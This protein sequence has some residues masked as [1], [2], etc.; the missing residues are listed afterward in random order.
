ML[1]SDADAV[2]WMSKYLE[3]AG[4]IAR[5]LDVNWHLTLDVPGEYGE[6]WKPLVI[7]TGD[8]K[9]FASRYAVEN[10]ENVIYFLTA[11][12]DN[13]NSILSCLR[14]A[15]QNAMR[16]RDIIPTEMWEALNVLYH[17]IQDGCKRPQ[18][19][20]KDPNTFC[21]EVKW[22]NLIIG[23]I[24]AD[25]MANDEA[26]R[27]FAMG[28]LLERADKTSRI[29]DVKYFMLLPSLDHV[30][31]ALDTVQW[32][33][34][35]KAVGG[36]QAFRHTH[37]RIVPEKVAEFMILNHEFP[38]SILYCLT[39][40]QQCLHDITGTRIGYF[41]NPAELQLG[42][43]CAGLSYHTIEEIFEQ[44]L[45]EFTDDLQIRF[46]VLGKAVFDTFFSRLPAI[47]QTQD[48]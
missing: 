41:T 33:A 30:G 26:W 23:G 42:Q 21:S 17:Y 31:T 29:L 47:E 13:P 24:A 35:L 32:A 25:I 3:R 34:L 22:R 11:D 1:S 46:N 2:Y 5:F 10:K 16:I 9:D 4:N 19:I 37:G 18:I 39:E 15:R 20:L 27:F 40:A 36:F 12:P 44:G 28:K 8:E 14:M 6:Q 48:Q 45:H 38:R 43:I 7:T